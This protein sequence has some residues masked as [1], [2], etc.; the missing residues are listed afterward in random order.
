[1]HGMMYAGAL[2]RSSTSQYRLEEFE[3]WKMYVGHVEMR[4]VFPGTCV[5]S[6]TV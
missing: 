5:D 4:K 6:N 1:V 2:E 3:L